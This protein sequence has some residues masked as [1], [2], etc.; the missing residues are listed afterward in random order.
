MSACTARFRTYHGSRA[1]EAFARFAACASACGSGGG[2]C[3]GGAQP[4]AA[5]SVKSY[6]GV[7]L[8]S[9]SNSSVTLTIL[10]YVTRI[11]ESTM[12][13]PNADVSHEFHVHDLQ[14]DA[15]GAARGSP[16]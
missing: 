6:S 8:G 2:A 11:V 12:R 5:L 15:G 16:S 3:A 10:A 14:R 1:L 9:T 4:P 13:V 7:K